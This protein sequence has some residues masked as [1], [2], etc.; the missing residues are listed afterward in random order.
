M[1]CCLV[2]LVGLPPFGGFVAKYWLL[3]ALGSKM[4]ETHPASLYWILII[5]AVINTLISLFFYFRIIKAMFLSD[6]GQDSLRP[7]FFG[8]AMANLCA[9]LLLLFGVVLINEPRDLAKRY[10]A[11]MYRPTVALTQ[12]DAPDSTRIASSD[13]EVRT[14]Q[15]AGGAR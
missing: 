1:V 6:D 10:S 9:V 7:P 3:L 2:S 5:V 4:G 12:Q 14:D 8:T 11:N 13:N 15:I